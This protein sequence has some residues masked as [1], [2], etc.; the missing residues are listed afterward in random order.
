[1]GQTLSDQSSD[2]NSKI[3]SE[4]ERQNAT[5]ALASQEGVPLAQLEELRHG[6]APARTLSRL[7]LIP[8]LAATAREQLLR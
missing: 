1:M 7:A 2:V 3:L 8:V 6:E 5:R 4:L